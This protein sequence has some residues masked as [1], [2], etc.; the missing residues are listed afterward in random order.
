MQGFHI[1]LNNTT[2]GCP[3]SVEVS[4]RYEK[5]ILENI[6][7]VVP[8]TFQQLLASK[9]AYIDNGVKMSRF[10]LPGVTDDQ[11]SQI[12]WFIGEWYSRMEPLLNITLN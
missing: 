7:K 1:N 11:L 2:N 6:R 9:E 3:V 4:T 10:A 8:L 5:P 12:A